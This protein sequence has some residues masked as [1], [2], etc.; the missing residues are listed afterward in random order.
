[1][2]LDISL[3]LYFHPEADATLSDKLPTKA[4]KRKTVKESTKAGMSFDSLEVG[5]QLFSVF[6]GVLYSHSRTLKLT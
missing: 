3:Y 2:H 5:E 1:M 6:I 4:K